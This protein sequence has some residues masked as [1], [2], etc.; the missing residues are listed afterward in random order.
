[1]ID[2]NSAPSF[3]DDEIT[4]LTDLYEAILTME[5]AEEM[6]RFFTD[7]CSVNELHSLLHRWQIVRRIEQNKS[8][9]EIINELSPKDTEDI[10]NDTKSSEDSGKRRSGRTK[11]KSRASTKVSSTTITR[12][13]KCYVNPEGG[14]R[15]ALDRLKSKTE[16]E[17]K[18]IKE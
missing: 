8:Y 15:T 17:K 10:S 5:T 3:G 9:E 1:M 7:L 2:R 11:G 6:H 13:K 12:V 16:K 14:Y 18:I 4:E